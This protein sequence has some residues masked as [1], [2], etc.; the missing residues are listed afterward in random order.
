MK[1]YADTPARRTRQIVGD[2][3]VVAWVVVWVAIARS[4]HAVISQLAAP[5]RTLESAGTSLED[6]LTSA[7]EQIS[8]VP[9]IGGQLEAPFTA[10]AGAASSITAAGISLQEAVAQVALVTAVVV[11]AWPIAVVLVTWL[12]ARIRFAV[13]ARAVQRLVA[14]GAGLDLFALRALAHQPLR[15]LAGVSADPAGDWRRNDPDVVRRLAD[16]ELGAAGIAVPRRTDSPA[17]D[18]PPE[19]RDA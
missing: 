18:A 7:G 19:A 3:L 1:L 6:G 10:A 9:L 12:R 4:V 16:L 15:V 17:L 8:G 13:R 5:G 2:L 11:A 14:G